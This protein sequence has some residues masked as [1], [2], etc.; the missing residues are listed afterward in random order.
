MV[1]GATR[2]NHTQPALLLAHTA[3]GDE[4]VPIFIAVIDTQLLDFSQGLG[5]V[6]QLEKNACPSYLR[7]RSLKIS[8]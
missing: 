3:L 7:K 6:S 1:L 8:D 2:A 4:A 5:K